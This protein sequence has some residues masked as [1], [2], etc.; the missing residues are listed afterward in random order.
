MDY[1]IFMIS[2]LSA[3]TST[4]AI[5][6]H[7]F[8]CSSA[9]EGGQGYVTLKW[10]DVTTVKVKK[11]GRDVL[12]CMSN[13]KHCELFQPFG[14]N[15]RLSQSKDKDK[16]GLITLVI[17]I[18]RA[19]RKGANPTSGVWTL[20]QVGSHN[21]QLD[22]NCIVYEKTSISCSPTVEGGTSH[23]DINLDSKIPVDIYKEDTLVFRCH[24]SDQCE[25]NNSIS[26]L[27][28]NNITRGKTNIHITIFN[29]SRLG[30]LPISGTW[31]LK[32][33]G[34]MKGDQTS[35]LIFEKPRSVQCY[36]ENKNYGVNLICHLSYV[37][38][39]FKCQFT[40]LNKHNLKTH[41]GDITYSHVL[42]SSDPIYH[43]MSC[44][45]NISWVDLTSDRVQVSV[46]MYANVSGLNSDTEE[47][48]VKL[49]M[50]I[51]VPSLHLK[52]CPARVERGA[53]VHCI[54]SSN[55]KDDIVSWFE[56]RNQQLLAET[57]LNYTAVYSMAFRCQL[58]ASKRSSG[59][60]QI[61][62][63]II[64]Y[65]PT[66][67]KVSEANPNETNSGTGWIIECD[68]EGIEG[69]NVELVRRDAA[70]TWAS[71]DFSKQWRLNNEHCQESK[72]FECVMSATDHNR[73]ASLAV[74]YTCNSHQDSRMRLIFVY[75]GIGA[76]VAISF[77]VIAVAVYCKTK[78]KKARKASYSY[79]GGV[80]F[81]N[82]FYTGF[83][84]PTE[85]GRNSV[86]FEHL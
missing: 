78:R 84:I 3:V 81:E 82:S 26:L 79:Q 19:T 34:R 60:H 75:V 74:Q 20:A 29:A 80:R 50:Y 22:A 83:E 70:I 68:I 9:K 85:T 63:P 73:N 46:S 59:I 23:I 24:K 6:L 51:D 27:P 40:T 47:G 13:Q 12:I 17:Q 16:D 54:C 28:T 21:K 32:Y 76:M 58:S 55:L 43:N 35:C 48:S 64:A 18:H 30:R 86:L 72:Y 4:G 7:S 25:P 39:L 71:D 5:D 45:V 42:T 77:A 36:Q 69:Q 44:S 56:E 2:L 66:V 62:N 31:K 33:F 8:T 37:Y 57:L 10:Y 61:F 1:T 52:D 38:P 67:R 65:P 11:D 49:H 53:T 15:V 14:P 41:F